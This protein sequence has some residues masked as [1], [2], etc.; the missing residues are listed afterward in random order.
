MS[1][2]VYLIENAGRFTIGMADDVQCQIKALRAQNACASNG[3]AHAEFRLVC[4]VRM[5][6]ATSLLISLH[7]QYKAQR[8]LDAP[9][10]WFDLTPQDASELSTCLVQL[11]L[12]ERHAEFDERNDER[13]TEAERAESPETLEP[14]EVRDQGQ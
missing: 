1:G 5:H 13:N 7:R 8:I 11:Y 10:D 4:A 3:E 14:L 2:C 12:D 6:E 9:G